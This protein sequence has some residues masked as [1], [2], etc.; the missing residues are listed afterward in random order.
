MNS[1]SKPLRQ[2]IQ[3]GCFFLLLWL[4]FLILREFILTLAWAFILA[5]VLWQPYQRCTTYLHARKGL[6]AALLTGLMTAIILFFAYGLLHLLQDEITR[7]YAFLLHTFNQPTF[8]LPERVRNLPYVG[9]YLQNH[10]NEL[11][12]NRASLNEKLLE[13]AKYGLGETAHLLRSFGQNVIKLCFVLITVFFCFRDGEKWLT[14][15]KLGG[16]YFLNDE[17]NIYLQTAGNT[18]RAV[19]YGLVL[20]ALGQGAVAAI[21]YEVAGV[22]TPVLLGALTALLA[23]IPMGATLVWLPTS[24]MLLA[25]EQWF[26]GLGLLAWG[27]L[28][29]STVDNIIRPL[30]IC[31]T[32]EVPFLVVLFGIF[33]G[34]TAFGAIGLFLGPIILTVLLAV[35]QE[36]FHRISQT[37]CNITQ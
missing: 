31:G 24:L 33:G 11:M 32:S 30:V 22:G 15:L 20:A 13:W 35:W 34:L 29:I 21:G 2:S 25:N 5:Y 27:L 28:A 26:A 14:Q 23:L 16:A 9:G 8:E 18:A 3:I 19:V 4:V 12:E 1:T 6:S 37:D 17:Q 7:A 36:F 10:I